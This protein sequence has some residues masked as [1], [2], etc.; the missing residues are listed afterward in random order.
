MLCCGS[1]VKSTACDTNSLSAAY[2]L[3]FLRASICDMA[4]EACWVGPLGGLP[5]VVG[6]VGVVGDVAGV[7]GEPAPLT[8]PALSGS[9]R[10]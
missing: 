9:M 4:C 3:L 6:K 1:A 8:A 10:I 5:G 2:C 7:R